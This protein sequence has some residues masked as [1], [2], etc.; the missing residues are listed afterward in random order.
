LV[1]VVAHK[2]STEGRSL[3][4]LHSQIVDHLASDE[5]A[6]MDFHRL[7]SELYNTASEEQL[8]QA[9]TISDI[10]VYEIK[11]NFPRLTRG[12][13]PHGVRDA[14]YLIHT[15]DLQPYRCHGS[16]SEVLEDV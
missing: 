9:N 13:V 12:S 14:T 7:C 10:R 4:E 5:L 11:D 8:S 16:L 2:S 6:L 3:K 15:Q 1:Y